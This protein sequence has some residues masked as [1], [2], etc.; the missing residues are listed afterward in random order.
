M[1]RD[2]IT[3]YLRAIKA[4]DIARMSKTLDPDRFR[5]SVRAAWNAYDA[6][7]EYEHGGAGKPDGR[8]R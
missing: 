5:A 6:L 7:T 2:A 4:L 3:E 8:T 1:S